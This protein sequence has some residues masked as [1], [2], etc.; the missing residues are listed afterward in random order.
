MAMQRRLAVAERTVREQDETHKK[1]LEKLNYLQE[2]N[3]IEEKQRSRAEGDIRDLRRQLIVANQAAQ[4]AKVKLKELEDASNQEKQQLRGLQELQLREQADAQMVELRERLATA[5]RQA[6]EAA[7]RQL[8]LQGKAHS[9]ELVSA[10]KQREAAEAMRAK[11]D[12]EAKHLR[13]ELAA[14]QASLQQATSRQQELHAKHSQELNTLRRRQ[15]DA[16]RLKE[17]AAVEASLLKEKLTRSEV[18]ATE[19]SAQQKQW[20]DEAHEAEVRVLRERHVETERRRRE[21]EDRLREAEQAIEAGSAQHQARVEE[22]RK[23]YAEHAQ[24]QASK[25]RAEVQARELRDRLATAERAAENAVVKQR[26]LLDAAHGEALRDIEDRLQATE[27]DRKRAEDQAATLREMLQSA[28]RDD[29]GQAQKLSAMHEES[30]RN[31][32]AQ[33][34]ET[35]ARAREAETQAKNLSQRLAAAER[36]AHTAASR[37]KEILDAAHAEELRAIQE[38]QAAVELE[39]ERAQAQAML[40]T[41]RLKAAEMAVDENAERQRAALDAAHEEE[42]RS[43]QRRQA[44]AEAG[45]GRAEQ[46][47]QEL[48]AK[49]AQAEQTAQEGGAGGGGANDAIKEARDLKERLAAMS[50]QLEESKTRSRLTDP[51]LQSSVRRNSDAS[52]KPRQP[53]GPS[54]NKDELGQALDQRLAAAERAIGNLGEVGMAGSPSEREGGNGSQTQTGPDKTRASG[55][56]DASSKPAFSVSGSTAPSPKDS[57]QAQGPVSRASSSLPTYPSAAA[58][59]MRSGQFSTSTGKSPSPVSGAMA[60]SRQGM[61]TPPHPG[62]SIGRPYR[63]SATG[64][65]PPPSAQAGSAKL[66]TSFTSTSSARNARQAPGVPT[67][68]TRHSMSARPPGPGSA[69]TGP[70]TGD[71]A[72]WRD[73][74]TASKPTTTRPSGAPSW[75]MHD[76]S[77]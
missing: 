15:A 46:Q 2:Q 39:K 29:V 41:E 71:A 25:E 36:A 3:A 64:G 56:G 8:E 74:R 16:D 23:V 57:S 47:A 10:R 52:K 38:R 67:G 68:E 65:A 26:Q 28:G 32:Q 13:S 14:T 31:L 42:L 24:V 49:L 17:Q 75:P 72:P 53:G 58:G 4:E 33:Q 27:A 12:G 77:R 44:A 7:K 1:T 48:A 5:E 76:P 22:L 21:A 37:Q 9:E 55:M 19:S 60:S 6:E 54:R 18:G 50:R 30:L 70:G 11:A 63:E 62:A 43:I 73:A 34:A 59:A 40:L 51:V 45:R 61:S 20:L 66:F 69:Q 35:E